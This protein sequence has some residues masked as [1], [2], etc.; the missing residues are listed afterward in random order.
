[1][2]KLFLISL[3][4]AASA[5]G[6]ANSS[7][8]ANFLIGAGWKIQDSPYSL[9]PGSSIG[10]CDQE[11]T[12]RTEVIATAV[13]TWLQAGGRDER[14][15]VSESCEGTR[16]IYLNK[17]SE[18]VNFYGRAHPL[19]GN[20]HNVDVPSQWAGH[21]T[22][23]H[24]VGHIFG[25]AHIFNDVISVMNSDQNGRFMNGGHLSDYDRSEIKRM[26][27]LEHFK[28]VN[29]LWKQAPIKAVQDCLGADGKTYYK[30]GVVTL[31][32]EQRF[33]CDDGNW[34]NG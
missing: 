31:Y 22:A 28:T 21:W 13:K 32:K 16:V 18:K 7:E 33:T 4:F 17:I 25:F 30:H 29:A 12:G 5:C 19:L 26:L 27:A 1:M 9:P 6:E 2:R 10:V 23:N 11:Q 3:L 34:I 8:L 14:I 20:I 15:Q 24:E